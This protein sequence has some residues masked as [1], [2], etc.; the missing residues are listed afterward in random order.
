MSFLCL[1][2]RGGVFR[3][4]F[5][6]GLIDAFFVV[7]LFLCCILG[8]SYLFVAHAVQPK[9]YCFIG[10]VSLWAICRFILLGKK[11]HTRSLSIDLITIG[12]LIICLYILW[13]ICSSE[14]IRPWSVCL[15]I[16][17][18]T[19]FCLVRSTTEIVVI[20][21]GD[22]LCILANLILSGITLWQYLI[23]GRSTG[24]FDNPAGLAICMTAL[25]PFLL[26]R[27]FDSAKKCKKQFLVLLGLNIIAIILTESRTGVLAMISVSGIFFYNR[28]VGWLKQILKYP[29]FIL[30]CLFIILATAV[31]YINTESAKGRLL[32]W[33]ITGDMIAEAPLL[34]GGAGIFAARYMDTQ[35]DFFQ[36]HPDHPMM[37]LADNVSYPFN[38]YLNF[39]AAYGL[40]GFI[41]CLFWV[42]F[43]ISRTKAVSSYL[44][45]LIAVSI[46]SLFSFP[47]RYASTLLLVVWC[48]GCLARSYMSVGIR[49]S[50]RQSVVFRTG[51]TLSLLGCLY[52][53]ITD[54]RFEYRWGQ[55]TRSSGNYD[56]MAYQ[57]LSTRWNG[58]PYFLYNYGVTLFYL[59]TYENALRVMQKCQ[60]YLNDYDV[61]MILGEC[62]AQLNQTRQAKKSYIQASLMCPN[63]FMPLYKLVEIYDRIGLSEQALEVAH[64]ILDKPEKVPS[65]TVI[66]IKRKM[67]QRIR[68]Q[69]NR[70]NT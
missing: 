10:L 55:L 26:C 17:G 19:L 65:C 12:W 38:E 6:F 39:I 58:N 42:L 23:Y 31:F 41:L 8:R 36:E 25:F 44:L 2:S 61:E 33:K 48:L 69:S 11:L 37:M 67:Q 51:A 70:D 46:T 53:M 47:F 59:G 45:S 43:V 22:G 7:C 28:H 62:Y 49:F 30:S 64:E 52:L 24:P 20:H 1:K 15:L 5:F 63:R 56:T 32:I 57:E 35:A 34:G 13:R 9:G 27:V 3:P 14:I 18:F 66:T 29:K 21:L 60:T 40:I 16:S 68:Q 54:L 4:G 50:I